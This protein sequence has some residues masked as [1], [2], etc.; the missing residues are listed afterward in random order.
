[1]TSVIRDGCRVVV[2]GLC[3]IQGWINTAKTSVRSRKY[4]HLGLV[5][6]KNQKEKNQPNLIFSKLFFATGRLLFC[7]LPHVL[8]IRT[9]SGGLK[10]GMGM[11]HGPAN[12]NIKPII[13]Y[14]TDFWRP[15]RGDCRQLWVLLGSLLTNCG[16]N[17]TTDAT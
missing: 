13:C 12:Q 5:T 3:R 6:Q 15:M 8:G 1:M 14:I 16:I 7:I 11:T 9:I 10:E 2:M 17:T 4:E